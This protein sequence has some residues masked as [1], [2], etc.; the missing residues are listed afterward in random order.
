MPSCASAL[1]GRD[2]LSAEAARAETGKQVLGRIL[3]RR[4]EDDATPLERLN[5]IAA[6]NA[7]AAAAAETASSVGDASGHHGLSSDARS[8]LGLRALDNVGKNLDT[9]TDAGPSGGGGRSVFDDE[10]SLYT[11]SMASGYTG[12]G[13]DVTPSAPLFARASGFP[14]GVAPPAAPGRFAK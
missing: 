6:A 8:L 2:Y 3:L 9:A 13:T 7:A 4:S 14:R 1:V 11:K 12:G 10:E 5:R